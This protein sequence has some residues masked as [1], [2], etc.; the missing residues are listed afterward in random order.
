MGGNAKNR[1]L[2]RAAQPTLAVYPPMR[3]LG[4][5]IARWA[6]WAAPYRTVVAEQ[7][8][9]ERAASDVADLL[10]A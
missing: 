5:Q 1:L 3:D 6:P 4:L 9:P 10:R 8:W 2:T 7:G